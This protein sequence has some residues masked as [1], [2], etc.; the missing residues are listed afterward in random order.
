MKRI[1]VLL[2]GLAFVASGCSGAGLVSPNWLASA[3][4]LTFSATNR[5]VSHPYMTAHPPAVEVTVRI[6]NDNNRTI[7]FNY[8]RCGQ[9][10]LRAFASADMSG[11]AIWETD[12]SQLSC[13]AIAYGLTRLAPGESVE[14]T[15]YTLVSSVLGTDKSTGTY[16]MQAYLGVA[17]GYIRPSS[18]SIP[19]G[20][21]QLSR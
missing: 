21:V 19:A 15:L 14:I 9:I 6:T 12:N 13:S 17:G 11:S 2:A 16:Y 7:P 4:I 1:R 3:D 5:V 10:G 18:V 8:S 20:A